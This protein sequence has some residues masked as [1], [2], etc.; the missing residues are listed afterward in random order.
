M[1]R[2]A[3]AASPAVES[4]PLPKPQRLRLR[5]RI[6]LERFF[7]GFSPSDC[8]LCPRGNACPKLVGI[9]EWFFRT[10]L[11]KVR[12]MFP[13]LASCGTT[14]QREAE[15]CAF[16]SAGLGQQVDYCR[17]TKGMDSLVLPA[18]EPWMSTTDNPWVGH[19]LLLYLQACP[20]LLLP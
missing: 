16:L 20:L 4:A 10:T 6:V 13:A 19:S 14:S 5:F 3:V 12:S 8:Q 17:T 7:V 1:I 11:Y 2:D 18:A 15:L 9:I